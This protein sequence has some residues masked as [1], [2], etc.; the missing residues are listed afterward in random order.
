MKKMK[1]LPVILALIVTILAGACTEIDVTPRS[2]EADDEPI[3]IA[4]S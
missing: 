2:G 1:K 4:P 3:V